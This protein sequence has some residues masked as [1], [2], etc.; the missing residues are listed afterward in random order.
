MKVIG[1][2]GGVSWESTQHY[3]RAINLGVR[4]ILGGLHSA[5]IILYSLDFADIAELQERNDWQKIAAILIEAAHSLEAA[6][7]DVL[8]LCTNTLH[9]VVPDIEPH[10]HIP[11]LHIADATADALRADGIQHVGLIG[12][13]YTMEQPF[14]K[15]R[16]EQHGISVAV[17]DQA[18]KAAI[19]NIIFNELCLGIINPDSKQQLLDII[20]QLQSSG[21]QAVV[22]GCTELALLVKPEDSDTP[23]YDTTAIHAARGVSYALGLP[24]SISATMPAK[25]TGETQD[26]NTPS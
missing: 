3:Y 25:P 24:G 2:L 7:A 14:Y 22:L 13:R 12:T 21:A 9:N 11:I 16:L 15:S 17:P 1:L 26:D 8:L 20:A 10:L 23:L 19:Q 4:E 18:G 6:G 5:R